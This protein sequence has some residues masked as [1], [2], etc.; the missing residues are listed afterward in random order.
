LWYPYPFLGS[1]LGDSEIL[2]L[3]KTFLLYHHD[4]N[5]FSFSYTCAGVEK[6]FEN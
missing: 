1:G 3:I 2:N 4:Y 6:I 5:A